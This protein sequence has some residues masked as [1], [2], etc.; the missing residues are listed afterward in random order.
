MKGRFASVGLLVL[1]AAL[2]WA[3]IPYYKSVLDALATRPLL[4][5]PLGFV[6]QTP[7]ETTTRSQESLPSRAH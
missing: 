4:L 6:R 7:I 2:E 3:A 5:Y 1:G